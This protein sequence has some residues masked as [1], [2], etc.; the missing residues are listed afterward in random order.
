METLVLVTR[1]LEQA[2]DFAAEVKLIGAAPVLCPLLDIEFYP[3]D[4]QR[5][6]KPDAIVLTSP[7]AVSHQ[8]FPMDWSGIPVFCV[9]ET[10]EAAAIQAG[11]ALR[12]VGV[13]NVLDLLPMIR[14]TL[15]IG[16]TILYLAG[17]DVSRDLT[18]ALPEYRIDQRIIY[19]AVPVDDFQHGIRDIFPK[20]GVITLFSRRTGLVLRD[21]LITN[22]LTS[23]AKNIKLLC[24]SSSVLDSV[25]DIDW[26]SCHVA[27]VPTQAA[28][29]E[30]LRTLVQDV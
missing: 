21:I 4:F 14:A 13:G 16:K 27:G 5:I 19:R 22:A 29:I 9:G 18:Q 26:A 3:A 17:E 1:P 20:I 6:P 23:Y 28:M 10:T 2:R 12:Y 30:E 8:T 24:L 25:G 7:N 15:A 11:A